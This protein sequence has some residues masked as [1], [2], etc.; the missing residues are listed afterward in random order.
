MCSSLH[1]R[2]KQSG[3]GVDSFSSYEKI[4]ATKI[5]MNAEIP[6]N[7]HLQTLYTQI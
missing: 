1:L 2:Y 4:G 5:L 6:V 3:A 7:F